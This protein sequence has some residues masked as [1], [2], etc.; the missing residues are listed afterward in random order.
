MMTF[1][2]GEAYGD[3]ELTV[4]DLITLRATSVWF[5]ANFQ[6]YFMNGASDQVTLQT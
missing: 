5:V 1:F 3:Y 6:S 4:Y 2:M